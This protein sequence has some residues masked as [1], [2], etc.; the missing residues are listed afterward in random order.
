MVGR[1]TEAAALTAPWNT[2]TMHLADR[3][4][5]GPLT[6]ILPA[7]VD[8]PLS[9][10]PGDSV[11][12]ITM[13]AV[14]PLRTLVR[15]SGPLAVLHLVRADGAPLLRAE[16]VSTGL[17]AAEDVAFIVDGPCG[18]PPPTVVDCTLSPPGV[19]PVGALPESYVE[20]ALLMAG[21]KRTWFTRRN[22]DD[23]LG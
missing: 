8:A 11:V 15:R 21:R 6:L 13:P 22:A 9:P 2:L 19:R 12:W 17:I 18:G 1:R 7:P 23:R 3:M 10:G 14:R 5:P 4:W 20:A 16:E